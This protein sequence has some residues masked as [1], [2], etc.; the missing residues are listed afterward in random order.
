[1]LD[2]PA[3]EGIEYVGKAGVT[4]TCIDGFMR[5]L[6]FD[7]PI[8]EA[9]LITHDQH[10]GLIL[11]TEEH[12][13]KLFHT[14]FMGEGSILHWAQLT[15]K[16]QAARADFFKAAYGGFRNP[17]AH[18]ELDSAP[19]DLLSEFLTLNQLFRFE[20]AAMEREPNEKSDNK[21][22]P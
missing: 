14:A 7:E 8:R 11:Y 3:S 15:N 19:E 12:G 13:A 10:H 18:K 4:R 6:Q 2:E 21:K 5:Y 1:M 20:R 22:T 17:R 9:K 16:E